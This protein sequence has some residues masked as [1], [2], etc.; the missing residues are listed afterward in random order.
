MEFRVLDAIARGR[1]DGRQEVD[2]K[3]VHMSKA[4]EI[5]GSR[6]QKDISFLKNVLNDC[7]EF[8]LDD[9]H[10]G[11]RYGAGPVR[12]YV[13]VATNRMKQKSI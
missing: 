8:C 9:K 13:E 2:Y 1:D 12:T 6:N 7:G 5:M 3:E 10:K 4:V 11:G